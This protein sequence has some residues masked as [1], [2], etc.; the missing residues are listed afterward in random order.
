MIKTVH[1][2]TIITSFS[3]DAIIPPFMPEKML[4]AGKPFLVGMRQN[5]F[6]AQ[7]TIL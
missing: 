1:K 2:I 7:K 5:S 4:L 3:F 6:V